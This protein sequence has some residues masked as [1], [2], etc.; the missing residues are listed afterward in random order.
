MDSGK[1]EESSVYVGLLAG[2]GVE[3]TIEDLLAEPP[4]PVRIDAERGAPRSAARRDPVYHIPGG[5]RQPAAPI[6]HRTPEWVLQCDETQQRA[7]KR[8]AAGLPW[9]EP[10][11]RPARAREHFDD[12]QGQPPIACRG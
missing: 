3:E 12:D 7:L 11:V 10:Y 6:R 5:R 8:L 1:H 2:R 9:D 4:A